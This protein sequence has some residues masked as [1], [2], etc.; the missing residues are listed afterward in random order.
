MGSDPPSDRGNVPDGSA[1][2][3]VHNAASLTAVLEDVGF[4]DVSIAVK[5]PLDLY[6]GQTWAKFE[7]DG[8]ERI[9]LMFTAR[10]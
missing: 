5:D 3:H 2:R 4:S 7:E 9:L 1:P 6:L 10:K 8:T